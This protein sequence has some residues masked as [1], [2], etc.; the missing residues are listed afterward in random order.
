MDVNV[1][2][3]AVLDGFGVWNVVVAVSNGVGD[4]E[5][6]EATSTRKECGG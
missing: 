6:S 3:A 2:A 1:F 4:A 5:G